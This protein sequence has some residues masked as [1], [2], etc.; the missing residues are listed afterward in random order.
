MKTVQQP[1]DVKLMNLTALVLF[2][3]CVLLLLGAAG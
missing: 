1:F 3:I 2:T